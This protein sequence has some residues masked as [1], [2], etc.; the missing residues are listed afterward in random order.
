MQVKSNN[1]KFD[2]ICDK[3]FFDL[4]QV[5]KTETVLILC[6]KGTKKLAEKI[7][8]SAFCYGK[9]SLLF[10]MPVMNRDGEEPNE[11]IQQLILRNDVILM[12]TTRSLSHTLARKKATKKGARIIS[13]PGITED[14]FLRCIDVDY[15]KMRIMNEKIKRYMSKAGMIRITT[16]LGT[17]LT[18]KIYNQKVVSRMSLSKKG[19]FDNLPSG[20]VF[21]S[22]LEGTANGI[23][24]ID[25]SVAGV[26]KLSNPI[27]VTVKRGFAVK[28]DGGK[29]GRKL[30]NLL[31]SVK[32]P[33]AFNLA[34]LGIGTNPKAKI[35]GKVLEDEKVKGTC[36]IALG[37][38]YSFGGKVSIPIHLDGI[39]KSPTIYFDKKKIMEKGKLLL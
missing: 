30:L 26:G 29:D 5:K 1:H 14:M 24:Y 23:Y 2:K 4:L 28:I 10:E 25:A 37:N 18:L 32:S 9:N 16:K 7:F 13:M 19:D 22:P 17:D 27:K 36:H 6:D 21:V 12:L 15:F 38:N 34:E 39:I 3:I 35:T 33:K 31:K 8:E 20:E 11:L